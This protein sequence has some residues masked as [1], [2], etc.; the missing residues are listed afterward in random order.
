MKS[1]KLKVL[2][3]R[4]TVAPPVGAWI[5]IDLQENTN[6]VKMVAPPVGAWI[7]IASGG[8]WLHTSLRRSPRGSVD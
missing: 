5:E 7:E 6:V 1:D 2:T 4:E 8:K 3:I